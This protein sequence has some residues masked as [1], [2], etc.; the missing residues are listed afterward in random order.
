MYLMPYSGGKIQKQISRPIFHLQ[1]TEK[2]KIYTWEV[3]FKISKEPK[4]KFLS[5]NPDYNYKF[6][7]TDDGDVPFETNFIQ[8]SLKSIKDFNKSILK[9]VVLVEKIGNHD[10]DTNSDPLVK[11]S[12]QQIFPSEFN[13]TRDFQLIRTINSLTDKIWLLTDCLLIDSEVWRRNSQKN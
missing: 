7:T 3:F 6:I 8:L 11:W 10:G 13:N 4:Y 5:K 1:M 12:L 9:R 2:M